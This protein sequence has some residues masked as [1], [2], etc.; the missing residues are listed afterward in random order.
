MEGVDK[1]MFVVD[2]K[3]LDYQTMKE[4]NRFQKD[5]VNGSADTRALDANLRDDTKRICVTTIQKLS[6]LIEKNSKHPIYDRHVVFI[7]DECHRSQFGKM[8]KEIVKKFKNYHLFGFTGTPIFAKNANMSGDPTLRTTEQAFGDRL[9]S[10]TIVNA[11]DNGNVLPFRVSYLQTMRA[12]DGLRD[13]QVQAI[14]TEGALT[15]F[16]RILGNA[17]YILDHYDQHTMRRASGTGFTSLLAT[18]SIPAARRYYAA[19]KQLQE[20]WAERGE[21]KHPVISK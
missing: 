8:H 13:D 7:F 3:D 20:I 9:H 12:K 11:I 4:Y 17:E 5:A 15:S 14:D 1:V 18:E 2:R 19:L 6:V 21:L 10:Y 16:S